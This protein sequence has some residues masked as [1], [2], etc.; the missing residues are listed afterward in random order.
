M[1][2]SEDVCGKRQPPI[3]SSDARITITNRRGSAM[4]HSK[5]QKTRLYRE[6]QKGRKERKG[7]RTGKEEGGGGGK[8]KSS[9][10]QGKFCN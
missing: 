2:H 1:C 3:R 7:K 9:K 10:A 4:C 8:F 5:H 6:N